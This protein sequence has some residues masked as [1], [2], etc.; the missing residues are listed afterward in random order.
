MRRTDDYV[1]FSPTQVGNFLACQHLTRLELRVLD[2]EL[3]RPGQ[4]DIERRLLEKR[5]L[6]HERRVLEALRARGGQVVEIEAGVGSAA[7]QKAAAATLAAM[8]AGA[9]LIYQ[10]TLLTPGWVGRPDFL[11]K[12]EG[13]GGRLPHH[14]EPMDAK[15]SRETKARAV[16]QL[17]AYADQLAELQGVF[18]R[19]FHVFPG[20]NRLEPLALL[21]A[22]YDAYF[23]SVRR[24]LQEFVSAAPTAPE[25]YPEPAEHCGICRFWKRCEDRR[26]SDDHLSL[27]AGISRRQRDRLSLAGVNRLEELGLLDRERRIEGIQPEPLARVREQAALQLRGRREGRALYE[28]LPAALPNVG[29]AALPKPTPGD[30]FLD[31]EGDSFVVDEGL[32]YLFGLV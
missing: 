17:C 28:L 18:P 6:E 24:R 11:R 26:R 5:G 13:G 14:Y 10:G 12:V 22:D 23:R 3:E 7:L 27:V 20:G 8:S 1:S 19:Q 15:L 31:L 32:E 2:G 16:L 25:P 4:N 30:L 21:T 9:D 29:L